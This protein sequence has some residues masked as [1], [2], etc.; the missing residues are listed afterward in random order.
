MLCRHGRLLRLG[1]LVVA[2]AAVVVLLVSLRA[3]ARAQG[4]LP[5]TA[6]EQIA[7]LA[8]RYANGLTLRFGDT[9][10]AT[11][12]ATNRAVLANGLTSLLTQPLPSRD[13]LELGQ[14]V[15][16][17]GADLADQPVDEEVPCVTRS[18]LNDVREYL[19]RPAPSDPRE[20]AYALQAVL[21]QTGE[22]F[23]ALRQEMA[24]QW[25]D[26]AQDTD[27]MVG[28]AIASQTDLISAAA[29]SRVSPYMKR[30]L[31]QAEV[32]ELIQSARRIAR[33]ERQGWNDMAARM[34]EERRAIYVADPG[35]KQSS[36]IMAAARVEYGIMGASYKPPAS[37]LGSAQ[38]F[39][40]IVATREAPRPR[41][42][43]TH[44]GCPGGARDF[45][46]NHA[47]RGRPRLDCL[48]PPRVP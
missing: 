38:E 20:A 42:R 14:W 47:P 10:S 37:V 27:E 12:I 34:P 8:D 43:A 3:P 36:M 16:R 30:L 19:S 41:R 25:S 32:D 44:E 15:E 26:V 39:Q 33:E 9:L 23:D 31:T 1:S 45:L 2:V 21:A 11:T 48:S 46:A 28:G 4:A 17:Q 13:L 24:A 6:G 35:P 7:Y 29:Y 18:L 22:V 5:T 40:A